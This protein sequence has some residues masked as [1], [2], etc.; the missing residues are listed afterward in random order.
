MKYVLAFLFL[1][2]YSLAFGQEYQLVVENIQRPEKAFTFQQKSGIFLILDDARQTRINGYVYRLDTDSI[3]VSKPFAEEQTVAWSDIKLVGVRNPWH[4]GFRYLS[5]IPFAIGGGFMGVGATLIIQSF[6]ELPLEVAPL[7]IVFGFLIAANGVQYAAIGS[8]PFLIPRR[9][10]PKSKY[11]YRF[12][13]IG[14]E[15]FELETE[16]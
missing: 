5:A 10:L 6:N 7:G 3:T 12:E 4:T 9:R 13:L 2:G 1:F 11:H 15:E 16:E 8:V 14:G